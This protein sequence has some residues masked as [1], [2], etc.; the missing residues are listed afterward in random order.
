M[1]PSTEQGLLA[2][3]P[4]DIDAFQTLYRAYF[5]RVY[6]YVAARV[7][8][9]QDAEDLVA[10]IFM[11]VVEKL[12]SFEW[13]GAGSFAAWVFRIAHLRV[14]GHLRRYRTR[15]EI[16]T[17]PADM[18]H[19]HSPDPTPADAL[20]RKQQAEALRQQVRL[21]PRRRQEVVT[22]RFF[23]GLRNHEIA[24]VLGINERTVASHLCRALDD[25]EMMIT[26]AAEDIR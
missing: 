2:R 9:R 7:A 4:D 12:G 17:D 15:R 1:D 6:G 21:L 3:L 20:L 5:P 14:M 11:I 24:D 23:G 26:A 13:R 25:L 19:V 16:A 8:Q 10:D 22:L 18:L